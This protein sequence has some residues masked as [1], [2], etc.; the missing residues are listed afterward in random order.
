MQQLFIKPFLICANLSRY[1]QIFNSDFASP[2]VG[3]HL[4]N[5][6]LFPPMTKYLR[7]HGLLCKFMLCFIL[8]CFYILSIPYL[9]DE[10]SGRALLY[11]QLVFPVS[12]CVQ[13]LH[14]K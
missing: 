5:R 1:I 13:Q 12:Y 3:C 10:I 9:I 7:W 4:S 2:Q 11:F 6:S 8:F 14:R